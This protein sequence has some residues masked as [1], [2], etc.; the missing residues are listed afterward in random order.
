MDSATV[1]YREM[2]GQLSRRRQLSTLR[3][4]SQPSTSNIDF[5]SND[6]LSLARSPILRRDFLRRLSSVPSAE[7]RLGSGGSRLLDGNSAYAEQLEQEIAAWHGAPAGLLANSGYDANVG[8]FTSVPQQGSVIVYDSFIHA[9]VHEGMRQS[10]A[11]TCVP[12]AHNDIEDLRRVISVILAGQEGFRE[13]KNS[14]FV[15]VEA[16]YSMDGDSVPLREVL[17]CVDELLPRGNGYV[18]VDEAHSTGL[19]GSRGRG[20][21]S[22]LGLESR[23]F[24]RL[25]TFGKALACNG[26]MAL[27]VV[28]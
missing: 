7:F 18:C 15:A 19:F 9:S 13:G 12:F 10:R 3:S 6:F 24:A 20:L 14:I 27:S 26:G 23:V 4:L 11:E 21:V 2:Q 16:L 5:S 25:H 22:E 17:D 28:P 8:L 1:L